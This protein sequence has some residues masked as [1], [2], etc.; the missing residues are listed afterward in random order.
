MTGRDSKGRNPW[1][2]AG[3]T[4]QGLIGLQG[5]NAGER[6]SS[7]PVDIVNW[8]G[9]RQIFNKINDLAGLQTIICRLE[10]PVHTAKPG[11]LGLAG[12]APGRFDAK[13]RRSQHPDR[14]GGDP[15]NDRD[16]AARVQFRSFRVHLNL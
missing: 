13:T 7:G 8:S 3:M 10:R 4:R 5:E 14:G 6:R 16:T 15:P 1:P 9:L 11:P 12:R 2:F